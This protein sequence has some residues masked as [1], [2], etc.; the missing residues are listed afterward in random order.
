M[1]YKKLSQFFQVS[2][3][4]TETQFS[5]LFHRPTK[6]LPQNISEY[7]SN[8]HLFTSTVY[9]WPVKVTVSSRNKEY[10]T[11]D[12]F[13]TKKIRLRSISFFFHLFQMKEKRN[14]CDWE[15][16]CWKSFESFES[17]TKLESWKWNWWP[18]FKSWTKLLM[19]HLAQIPL[20]KV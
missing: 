12:K 19:F 9:T 5:K 11:T 8:Q 16:K 15:T 18:E 10:V 1:Y 17:I 4:V 3:K 6:L 14:T 13:K 2:K 20:G 7:K